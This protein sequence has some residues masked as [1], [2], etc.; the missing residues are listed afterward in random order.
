M[1][2]RK[3][4]LGRLS[5]SAILKMDSP[6]PPSNPR[7]AMYDYLNTGKQQCPFGKCYLLD[8]SGKKCDDCMKAKYKCPGCENWISPGETSEYGPACSE[9]CATS[10]TVP[11]CLRCHETIMIHNNNVPYK[12]QKCH[13][14]P[15]CGRRCIK[16][17]RWNFET[18]QWDKCGTD[19]CRNK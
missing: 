3:N 14:A 9:K 7:F 13:D 2:S 1:V 5:V 6:N 11:S 16:L 8:Q 10:P 4:L 18:K 17:A 19:K 15:R 12:C